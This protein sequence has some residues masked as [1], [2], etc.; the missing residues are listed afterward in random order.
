MNDLKF[1][2]LLFYYDRPNLVQKIS[3]PS[4]FN[5]SYKNWELTF[6]DDSS[7][8]SGEEVIKD[9]LQKDASYYAQK[10]KL[11][12]IKTGDTLETKEARGWESIFG[13]FAN[14]A[15]EKHSNAD[16]CLMLCD[17]D[18]LTPDYLLQLN[19]FYKENPE[20]IY[21]YCHISRFNPLEITSLEEV[22]IETS[23]DHVNKTHAINNAFC[24]VDASQVS[25]RR[26]NFIEDGVKF[27]YPK[28]IAV[29]AALYQSMNEKWGQKTDCVFNGIIGQYK[30][31][32]PDQLGRREVKFGTATGS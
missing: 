4:V 6:I 32:F 1:E 15:L 16:I 22:P 12:L 7:N 30:G 31:V 3:L 26:Q 14:I 28:T 10:G 13:M 25:W 27:P 18:G 17:D 9:F 19:K 24:E 20:V 8:Q 5:S 23:D 29:D 21:S 11:K 2:I